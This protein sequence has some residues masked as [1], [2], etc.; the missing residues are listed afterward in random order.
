MQE[1]KLGSEQSTRVVT[2]EDSPAPYC[3]LKLQHEKLVRTLRSQVEDSKQYDEN[4][5][6]ILRASFAFS[7]VASAVVYYLSRNGSPSQFGAI[8]NPL[9]YAGLFFGLV[10]LLSSVATITHTKIESE[11]NPDD[12]DTQAQFGEISLLHTAV[13]TYPNYIRRN[14]RR[15][16]TDKMLLAVSQYSLVL[17]V[18]SVTSSVLFFLS[19]REAQFTLTLAVTFVLGVITGLGTILVCVS[20]LSEGASSGNRSEVGANANR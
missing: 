2:R 19:D 13:E 10:S 8:D 5:T 12:L 18:L 6:S 7:S 14:R 1:F 15:L 11:L 3:S 16:S 20:L 17:A 9:T 4:A